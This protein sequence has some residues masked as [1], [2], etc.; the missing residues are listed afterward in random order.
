MAKYLIQVNYVGEGIKGL[1]KE[2]GTARRIAVEKLFQSSG[3]TIESFYYAFGDTDLF[4]IGDF[5]DAA[6]VA[7]GVL[8]VMSTGMVTCKTTPLLTQEDIDEAA[9]KTPVYSPPGK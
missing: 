7:A 9:K 5:P 1:L 4:I 6:T 8:T 2:G 3:S